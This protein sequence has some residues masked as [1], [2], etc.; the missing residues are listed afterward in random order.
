[1]HL[2]LSLGVQMIFMRDLE[3]MIGWHRIA[4]IYILSGCIGSLTSGIFL[5]YQV[6]TGPTAAQFS[7]LGVSLV[8]FIYCWQYL[9]HPWYALLRNLFLILVLFTFGLLPWIDNYA[10]AG[11][12]LSGILLSFILLPFRGLLPSP[13]SQATSIANSVNQTTFDSTNINNNN[14]SNTPVSVTTPSIQLFSFSFSDIHQ[15]KSRNHSSSSPNHL[16][17][18]PRSPSTTPYYQYQHRQY[19]LLHSLQIQHHR[20]RR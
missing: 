8:D 6:E 5:P 10:N 4:L 15:N 7:L 9:T 14:S 1:M 17:N 3:K 16:H 11:S 19:S 13:T 20:K 2:I 12:F 18:L